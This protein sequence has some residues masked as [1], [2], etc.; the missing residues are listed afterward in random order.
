MSGNQPVPYK[1]VHKTVRYRLKAKLKVPRPV[2]KKQ[3]PGACESV[4]QTLQPR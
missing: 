3:T 2:S 4:Q 1:T